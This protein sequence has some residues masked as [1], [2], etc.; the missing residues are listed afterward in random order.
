MSRPST[1]HRLSACLAAFLVL[2]LFGGAVAWAGSLS[3]TSKRLTVYRTC[4]IS[5]ATGT[6]TSVVDA[7]VDQATPAVPGSPASLNINS[8]NGKVRR[9]YVQFDLSACSP[10]VPSNATVRTA[11]LRLYA[12]APVNACRSHDLFTVAAAWSESTLTWANQP[13]GTTLNN[14]A[15]AQ[16][17]SF[18]TIGTQGGCQN[19][20]GGYVTGWDVTSDVQ[21]FVTGSTA[22]HGWMIRDDT[23]ASGKI[24]QAYGSKGSGSVVAAPQLFV[25]YST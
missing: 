20:A 24:A 11:A 23:E 17:K 3:V 2:G 9:T 22:N 13:F 25:T 18:L 10:E 12:G 1:S 15:Q 8:E 5:A 21:A 19:T 7:Y 4:L 6:S 16:R 14:P